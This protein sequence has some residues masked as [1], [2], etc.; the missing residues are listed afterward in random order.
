MPAGITWA[1][2]QCRSAANNARRAS[3]PQVGYYIVLRWVEAGWYND[4]SP[5]DRE[6]KAWN[7][8]SWAALGCVSRV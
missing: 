5:T 2:L 1:S 8:G 7:I 6:E 4:D 3:T